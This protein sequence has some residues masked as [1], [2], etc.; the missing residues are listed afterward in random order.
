MKFSI[1]QLLIF[2]TLAAIAIFL[3]QFPIHV[4]M[5]IILFGLVLPAYFVL[6]RKIWRMMSYGGLLGIL[7]TAMIVFVA[8]NITFMQP[9]VLNRSAKPSR[10]EYFEA[11]EQINPY[12]A[13]VGFLI[14]STLCI[15]TFQ[16][17]SYSKSLTGKSG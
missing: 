5:A 1:A 11:T 6:E 14:G 16:L 7:V 4:S 2:V 13:P 15:G 17:I 12:I 9:V 3:T 8:L 10:S